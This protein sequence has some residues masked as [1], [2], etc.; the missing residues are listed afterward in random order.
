[1]SRILIFQ[2]V[3]AEPLGTLDPLI[4]Q[5]GH[6]MRF[7]NFER[8]PDAQPNM[9]R[10][11]GLIVLGGPM[12]VEEQATRSHLRTELE[13]IEQALK[14]DKPV[15]GICLGAQ[16]LA[17]A[18]GAAVERHRQPEI[19]WY[20]LET[21]AH[22]RADPVVSG[23][24][25][26]APV[27]Q[28]H[29]RSFAIPHGATHLATTQTC[30]NQAFRYGNSAYGF[31]FHLEMDQALIERWVGLPHYHAELVAAGLDQDAASIVARTPVAMEAMRGSAHDVFSRFLDRIGPARKSALAPMQAFAQA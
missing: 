17:H 30:T 13:V 26:R 18:L 19:G 28:W 16:L 9:D 14:Q 4:R 23:L 3:A 5:R 22:G 1:M 2:H 11:D 15:L 25:L 24:G 6:R 29:S 27:F 31:Q 21:N 7:V 12:N 20:E 8:Q 10:Y